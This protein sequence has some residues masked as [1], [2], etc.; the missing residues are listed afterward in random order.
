MP[1][2]HQWREVDSWGGCYCFCELCGLEVTGTSSARK[3]PKMG[4]IKPPPEVAASS[5]PDGDGSEIATTE[6]RTIR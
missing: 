6:R 3:C 4:C 5:P 1:Y 2:A